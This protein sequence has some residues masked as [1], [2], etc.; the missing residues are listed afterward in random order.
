VG[1]DADD[2]DWASYY[3]AQAGRPPRPLLRT[4]LDRWQAAGNRPG[5]A[6]DLGCG[7]GADTLELLRQGWT[8]LTVD[9]QA[10]AITLVE[11][12]VPDRQRPRLQTLVADFTALAL[13]AADLIYCGWSLP[14]CPAARFTGTWRNIRA[15]LRPHGRITAHLLGHRD[16]WAPDPA[17]SAF[18]P[19]ALV[20]LLAGLDVEHLEEIEEDRDSF[21]GPKH[22]HYYEII[23]RSPR[24]ARCRGGPSRL[25]LR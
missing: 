5:F 23:A 20:A 1:A 11:R 9:R 4:V 19:D 8:V 6:I 7:D 2:P 17:S 12:N 21:D 13:P 25:G 10:A 24:D 22:W 3:A 14:H 16:D 18:G 15:A